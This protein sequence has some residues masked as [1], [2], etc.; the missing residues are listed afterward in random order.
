MLGQHFATILAQTDPFDLAQG[1]ERYVRSL[2]GEQVRFLITA[3]R[4]LMND[5]YRAE[6]M[7]LLEEP[8]EERV[9]SGFAHSLKSNLRAITLFGPGFCQ[10]VIAQLPGDRAVGLGEERRPVG[11]LRPA[12]FGIIALVLFFGGAAAQHAWNSARVAAQT[13]P[14]L[15]A[16]PPDIAYQTPV[17]AAAAAPTP[18]STATPQPPAPSPMRT[19]AVRRTAAPDR[20]QSPATQAP[21]PRQEA[22][23]V[24]PPVSRPAQPVAPPPR[25]PAPAVRHTPPP[26]SGVKTIV[27]VQHTPA[28][29]PEPTDVDVS[30]MPQA[31]TDATP[32]PRDETPPPAQVSTQ[33]QV[34]TPTPGPN[35]YWLHSTIKG[36]LKTIDRINP[37][38]HHGAPDPSASPSGP[39]PR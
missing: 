37:F 11:R 3:A 23:A 36:T 18:R 12:A 13:R 10:G 27:A 26:G 19:A 17:P 34:P 38:K 25:R 32:L 1:V 20:T 14:D 35:R 9:R 33:T 6:F 22:V 2:S 30:D 5:G 24:A 15:I 29:S 4:P 21:A 31:F 8:D 28:P 16:P 7:P 39:Q